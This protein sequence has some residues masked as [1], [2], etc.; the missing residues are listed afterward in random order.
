MVRAGELPQ[1][2]RYIRAYLSEAR[3]GLIRDLGPTEEDLTAAQI[4]LIDRTITALGIIRCI[5]EYI[6]E[7]SVMKGHDLSPALQQSYIAY[8]NH[9]RLNLVALG[10]K[11][12]ASENV[13]DLPAYIEARDRDKERSETKPGRGRIK[14]RQG[15]DEAVGASDHVTAGEKK[16][17]P[18]ASSRDISGQPESGIDCE[19]ESGREQPSKAGRIGQPGAPHEAQDQPSIEIGPQKAPRIDEREPDGRGVAG[20]DQAGQE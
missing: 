10:I 20:E 14:A 2:R 8:V 5:E 16:I 18:G 15:Q 9:V 11:T 4:I 1:N 13:L 6:R 19:G 7:T 3:A 17:D 12:K